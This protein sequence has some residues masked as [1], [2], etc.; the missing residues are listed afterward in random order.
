[1]SVETAVRTVDAPRSADH[2]LITG[3]VSLRALP[4]SACSDCGRYMPGRMP[5]LQ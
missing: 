2:L 3:L 4:Y 1:M 5:L